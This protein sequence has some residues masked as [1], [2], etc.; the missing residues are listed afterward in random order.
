MALLVPQL[1]TIV[2]SVVFMLAQALV[3]PIVPKS[4]LG[5]VSGNE[6]EQPSRKA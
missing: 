1:S 2:V 6:E 5:A 3:A 4:Q